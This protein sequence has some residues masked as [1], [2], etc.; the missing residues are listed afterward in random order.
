MPFPVILPPHALLPIIA[1][2]LLAVTGLSVAQTSE[3]AARN[4]EK[5][6]ALEARMPLGPRSARDVGLRAMWRYG[7]DLAQIR[8]L[9]MSGDAAFLVNTNN[10]VTMINMET[11]RR[12]WKSFG[13]GGSDLIVDIVLVKEA[14]KVVVVRSNSILTLSSRTG[15][16]TLLG[17]TQS[18]VQPL[19][20][21][22]DTKGSMYGRAYIYGGLAGEVVWQDWSLGFPTN[23][24]R[25]GRKVQAQPA[26]FGSSVVASSRTG[27]LV[28]MAADDGLLHWQKYLLGPMAGS[29]ASGTMNES[30]TGDASTVTRILY[31]AS[32]DQHL[33]AYNLADGKLRWSKLFEQPLASGP[34]LVDRRVIQQVPGTGLV[35]MEGLP[36][37]APEGKVVWTSSDVRGRV[38]GSTGDLLLTW[39]DDTTTL[40]TV[41]KATGS[42]DASS[43][44]SN[45]THMLMQD[46]SLLLLGGQGELVCYQPTLSD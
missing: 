15:L 7:V 31:V 6:S 33:R 25:I 9:F 11:G 44:A 16:P 35:C 39:D 2:S 4:A 26:V 43:A 27:E 1:S 30:A 37:D 45:V 40:Q 5:V 19:E 24:H 28:A 29:P 3:A 10:E 32:R 42:V 12:R 34:V 14:E 38:I 23:V 18:S 46:D 41:S 20:W 8:S 22:S 21:I 13:G 17:T 36:P